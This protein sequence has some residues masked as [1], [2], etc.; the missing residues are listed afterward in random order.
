MSF[1]GATR[2]TVALFVLLFAVPGLAAPP[3]ANIGPVYVDFGPVKMGASVKVPVVF[4]NLAAFPL[5]IAGGGMTP[6]FGGNAGTCSGT[7][8]VGASCAFEYEF[9]PNDLAGA[10]WQQS[11]TVS[12]S[13][14]GQL[15][16]AV[17]TF[18]GES[19]ENL[20]Q[21]S[22]VHVDFGEWPIGQQVNVPIKVTN[23]HD[24][25]ITFAGGG[26]N[27][28]GFFGSGQGGTCSGSVAA[29]ASCE[30]NYFFTPGAVGTTSNA[31]SITFNATGVSAG[32]SQSFPLTFAGTGI[33][34]IP[35]AGVA[36]VS[37]DFGSITIGRQAVV[38]FRFTNFNAQTINFGGGGFS[39]GND[40]DGSLSGLSAGGAGCGSGTAAPG[41]TCTTNYA[42]LP[43][44]PGG[45]TGTTGRVFSLGA[46]NQS[47]T[48][49]FSGTGVGTLARITP[50]DFDVGRV[51]F[52]TSLAVPV[53]ITNTSEAP[54]T[55][56]IGGGVSYPFSSTTTCG[57][58]LA[59]GASCSY[60]YTFSSGNLF[61]DLRATVN[62]QTLISF[63]NTTGI[64]PS[65]TITMSGTRGDRLFG[66]AFEVAL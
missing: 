35:L 6:P 51:A 8:A 55:G 66:D 19:R 37:I 41:A 1:T 36:P 57:A 11:T 9:R 63:T 28:P 49:N 62:R 31:T 20:V 25:T 29:G 13:G 30:F 4:R 23:T 2:F 59:V 5:N 24:S 46:I 17:L 12:V 40:G 10:I 47:V 43:R 44:V 52:T 14:A 3:L 15:Q 26:F 27:N 32:I 48:Y 21:V 22:P 61:S 34:T 45:V 54:L 33:S 42:F 53:T 64:Q 60:L 16:S 65:F 56:F 50:L 58:S 39:V 7:I 18:A 38:P